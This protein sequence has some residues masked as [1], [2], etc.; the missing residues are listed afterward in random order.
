MHIKRDRVSYLL[1]LAV[2][3][4]LVTPLLIWKGII[5]AQARWFSHAAIVAMIPLSYVR[6]MLSSGVP[7]PVYYSLF[8]LTTGAVVALLR[9]QGILATAW[10]CWLMVQFPLVGLYSYLW[11]RWPD[12]FAG[13][14]CS[15][16]V[17]VVVLQ[18]LV[19]IAQ[20]V[21]GQTP[22]DDLSGLFGEH[23]TDRLAIFLLFVYCLGLGRWMVSGQWRMAVLV[24]LL[25]G[26]SSALGEMK[27]FPVAAMALTTAAVFVAVVR[28]ASVAR[29]VP[30][31][32]ASTVGLVV[33]IAAYEQVIVAGG[34]SSRSIMDFLDKETRDRYLSGVTSTSDQASYMG[35]NYALA[36]GW[37]TISQSSS[38][39]LLGYGLGARGE[40]QS[41]GTAGAGLQQEQGEFTTGTGL[42][43]LLH[44]MGSFGLFFAVATYIWINLTLVRT[45]R[46]QPVSETQTLCYALLLF[47]LLWPL[48]F[49]YGHVL[50]LRVPMLFYW[51]TL[52]YVLRESETEATESSRRGAL[53]S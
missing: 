9:G 27:L 13:R 24:L 39:W 7:R 38:T 46:R 53:D 49:W 50:T 1:L 12:D 42:L 2:I 8:L 28:G 21:T 19:Q 52:G 51:G 34:Y 6:M 47:S 44:E 31:A 4:D 3:T 23:G 29:L 10:G 45:I 20:Y 15:F 43:V 14:L 16:C 22:G 41:L 25:G 17:S 5:P 33:C 48:W 30:F 36:Y 11:R 18:V 40:S 32:I 37:E 35:R 26:V